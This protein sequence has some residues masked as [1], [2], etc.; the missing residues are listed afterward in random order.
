MLANN[1]RVRL[2]ISDPTSL[3]AIVKKI[4]VIDQATEVVNAALSPMN[5][6]INIIALQARN[7][8]FGN[9]YNFME[10]YL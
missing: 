8:L 1:S 5:L 3:L 9:C 6:S 10:T 7:E 2:T 4:E